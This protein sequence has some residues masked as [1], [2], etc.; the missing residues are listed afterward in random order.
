MN[1]IPLLAVFVPWART[2]LSLF[3]AIY[4]ACCVLSLEVQVLTS[5]GT[6]T[7]HDLVPFNLAA[8]VGAA[9]WQ[10]RRGTP[11]WGWRTAVGAVA[12]WPVLVGLAALVMAVNIALPIEAADAYQLERIAQIERVGTLDYNLS[13]D[14]KVNITGAFYELVI[15]DLKQIPVAGPLLVRMHGVLGLL[16][17]LVTLATVR[18]WFGQG[19]SAWARSL[20]LVVPVVFHQL[21]LIKNDLF[22]AAPSLVVL[23]WLV[24]PKDDVSWVDLMWAGWLTGLVVGGKGVN[25][26]LAIVL[27]LG[28]WLFQRRRILGST[29][30]IAVGGAVGAVCSGLLLTAVLNLRVYGDVV[31]SGPIGEMT[32]WYDS[33]AHAA[34]GVM[35]FAISLGDM[36]QIT[37][38]LWPG[39]G[40]WG[41]TFGLPIVWALAVLI[42][43]AGSA[44]DARRAL[45]CAVA[46]LLLFALGFP[47]AD[48][49]HR[50]VLGPGLLLLVVALQA[51]ARSPA[52][53]P[54][55]AA[56]PVV[57]LSAAQIIRS[58]VLYIQRS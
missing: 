15:A 8:A 25:F 53:W 39:R 4:F 3:T 2:P 49:A 18:T 41:G 40:G 7:L 26:P 6:G 35:R 43:H 19:G 42:A 23:A 52:R 44:R 21:I 38:R 24:A 29:A 27:V 37:T 57:L 50:I 16:L 33:P 17:Y 36:G 13:A 12:P 58:A 5:T 30:W 22:F 31:A 20:L 51:S 10:R 34:T 1:L 47:D 28:V 46:F 14:P 48:L 45:A 54:H 55:L 9:V 56:I 11:A 32:R